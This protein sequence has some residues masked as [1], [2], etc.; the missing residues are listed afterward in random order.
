MNQESS[1]LKSFT[2]LTT[3]IEG[4]KLVL[5]I[6]ELTQKF[7][8]EEIFGLTNQLRRA[9]VS[10][11]S[12]IAA[13]FSRYSYKEKIQFYSTS[14]G[15]LTE[16]QNQLLIARDVKYISLDEFKKLAELTVLNN[17]LINGLIKKSKTMIHD[18]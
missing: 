5:I 12:N 10:V 6:Y 14:L 4:H 11:T 15:S 16:V 18:S 7:P 3:W 13:G 2:K 8:K 17:E 9:A 1:K